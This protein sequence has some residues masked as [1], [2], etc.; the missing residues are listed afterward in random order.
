MKYFILLFIF[1]ISCSPIK[2]PI[3]QYCQQECVKTFNKKIIDGYWLGNDKLL[4]ITRCFCQINNNTYVQIDT[5]YK[6]IKS[7][8]EISAYSSIME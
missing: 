1:L 7:S 2:S 3:D 4:N 8:L 6:Y 5:K